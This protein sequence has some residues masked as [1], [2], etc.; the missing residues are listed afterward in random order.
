MSDK[1]LKL[2]CVELV[3]QTSKFSLTSLKTSF[4]DIK[5]VANNIYTFISSEDK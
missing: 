5:E 1:E 4:K 2:K 3:L